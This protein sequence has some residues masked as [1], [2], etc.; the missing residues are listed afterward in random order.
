MPFC[1]TSH[2]ANKQHCCVLCRDIFRTRKLLWPANNQWKPSQ[3]IRRKMSRLLYF[4][5]LYFLKESVTLFAPRLFLK[6][7]I[8]WVRSNEQAQP[9]PWFGKVKWQNQVTQCLRVLQCDWHFTA[10][11]NSNWTKVFCSYT[12]RIVHRIVPYCPASL[13]LVSSAWCL[14]DNLDKVVS[15]AVEI[16]RLSL[17]FW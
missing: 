16:A 17:F 13:A 3:K 14:L 11:P 4:H 9:S 12:E 2:T 7:K 15:L 6:S 1:I 5:F 8:Y 10:G